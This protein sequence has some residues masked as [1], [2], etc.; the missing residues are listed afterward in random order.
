MSD[1]ETISS[2]EA[3]EIL[4]ISRV[5]V[6]KWYRKGLLPGYKLGTHTSPVRFDRAGILRFLE[7]R[8][9]ASPASK[10]SK[11]SEES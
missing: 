6:L 7:E 2:L 11:T 5:T 4:G 10:Q 8:K 9:A 3:A 1:E